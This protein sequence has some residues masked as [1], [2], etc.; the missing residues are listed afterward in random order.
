M[1]GFSPLLISGLAFVLAQSLEATAAESYVKIRSNGQNMVGTLSLP[2]GIEKPPV[3]LM[4]HGFTGQ[5]NEFPTPE[6][7]TPLFSHVAAVLA[8]KGIAT[9]RIDFVGSGE[10][11]GNWADTT[12]NSQ[13]A[14]ATAAFDYLQ[15]IDSVDHGRV[16]VL[17]YSMGGLVGAHLAGRRPEATAVMLWA[18]VTNPLRTFSAI[19]GSGTVE[20]A[21]L[22]PAEQVFTTA[23]SWGGKTTLQAGFF[24]QLVTSDP[25]G[26]L[27]AYEGPLAVVVGIK[28]SIVTPQPLAGQILL[29]YH[30]GIEKLISI[31]SDHDWGWEKSKTIVDTELMPKTVAWFS[32]YF[33]N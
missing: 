25:A 19:A 1:Q 24:Q 33:G 15:S 29:D 7:G 13:I 14:D 32:E 12:F 17:G 10:S 28:D 20:A 2:D 6:D 18:P 30:T 21:L 16:G 26:A 27:A 22:A 8:N 9:L 23:L 3:V 5:R 11:G 31:D 4:L